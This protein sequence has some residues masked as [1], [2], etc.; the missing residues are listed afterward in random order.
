MKFF[1][2]ELSRS[3]SAAKLSAKLT[4]TTK[5]AELLAAITRW[6]EHEPG[7]E[8]EAKAARRVAEEFETTH[9]ELGEINKAVEPGREWNQPHFYGLHWSSAS[10]VTIF[11]PS[12]LQMPSVQN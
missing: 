4:A 12:S 10:H 3:K 2:F 9:A 1:E 8:K 7:M 5:E 6:C 11:V